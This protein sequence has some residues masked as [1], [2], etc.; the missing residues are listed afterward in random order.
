MH[1]PVGSLSASGRSQ[2][3]FG[4]SR[5]ASVR[6]IMIDRVLGW[7]ERLPGTAI[8]WG[9]VL[10]IA[11]TVLANLPAWLAGA[12]P[13]GSFEAA[14]LAP[15]LVLV[16]FVGLVDFLDRIA[17]SA[18]DEF[19]PALGMGAEE[20]A[21][22]RTQLTSIPDRR[23]EGQSS[24]QRRQSRSRVRSVAHG[25][26]ACHRPS[27]RNDAWQASHHA[28][29]GLGSAISQGPSRAFEDH[30]HCLRSRDCSTPRRGGRHIAPGRCP[31]RGRYRPHR[32]PT[33]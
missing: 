5:R 8:P 29:A 28:R 30:R 26:E 4:P 13:A 32:C 31:C 18:F 33:Q 16:Y 24:H 27:T 6:P 20:V 1:E 10:A 17:R 2:W 11:L 22:L 21:R 9:V 3:S 23:Y 7:L 14:F 19:R 25:C 15:I 12:R